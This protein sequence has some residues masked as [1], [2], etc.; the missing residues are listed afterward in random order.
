M[1][2]VT[3]RQL[4]TFEAVARLRSFSAA[5]NE[6]HVS[7][8]TVSKQIKALHEAIELPLI[9]QIGKKIFVTEAGQELYN[10]CHDWLNT[11]ERF[12]QSIANLK[13]MKQG[14]LRI[15]TVTTTKY[16]MPRVL[17]PFCSEYPNID[18]SLNVVNRNQLLDRL[19][20]NED[21]LYI[22]GVPPEDIEVEAD[23]FLDNPLVVIA[24]AS[25]PLSRKNNISL[26]RLAKEPFLLREAGSGTRITVE[27]KFSQQDISL[28]VRMELGSNEAIK[29]AVIGGLGVSVL[30]KSTLSKNDLAKELTILDVKGFP[31]NRAWYIVWPKGKTLSVVAD[32][33]VKFLREYSS[34]M[35]F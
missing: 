3:L 10:T 29:Q 26:S 24:H 21:D 5:A 35:T 28:N 16:F 9:E 11:W 7:Q 27:K 12:E 22:M 19:A 23:A 17:G 34:R 15:T 18:I 25:H 30:S 13:G 1:M 33:F 8:P 14:K 31:I 2:R 32:S 6:M 20:D 4:S